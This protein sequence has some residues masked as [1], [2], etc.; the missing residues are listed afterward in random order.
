M[1]SSS[2]LSNSKRSSPGEF[3]PAP[4]FV[5]YAVW[6]RFAR[7]LMVFLLGVSVLLVGLVMI[8]TP[9]P[10][11]VVIPLGLGI[12]ATEFVWARTILNALKKRLLKLRSQAGA[13]LA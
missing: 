8:I 3:D 4:E 9:G 6:L 5:N 13:P 2:S 12:L 10:A 1:K 11:F 7:R